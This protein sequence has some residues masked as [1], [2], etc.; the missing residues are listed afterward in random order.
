[1]H[2]PQISLRLEAAR[3]GKSQLHTQFLVGGFR[4]GK[5]IEQTSSSGLQVQ[6]LAR[7]ECTS[8]PEHRSLPPI[9]GGRLRQGTN[10]G[11]TF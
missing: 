5:E 9:G 11:S 4:T 1:M 10:L 7:L 3:V 8:A 6:R 2:F